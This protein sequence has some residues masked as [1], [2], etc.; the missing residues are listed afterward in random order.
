VP[1]PEGFKSIHLTIPP[2][3]HRKMKVAV[4]LKGTTLSKYVMSL[5]AADMKIMG[6]QEISLGDDEGK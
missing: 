5:V 6:A 2:D 4:A 1:K 3:F